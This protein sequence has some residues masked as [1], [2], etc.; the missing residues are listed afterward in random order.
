MNF[1]VHKLYLITPI[2]IKKNRNQTQDVIHNMYKTL[3]VHEQNGKPKSWKIVYFG[4]QKTM[5]WF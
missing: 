2:N 4:K 5:Q 1:H 3:S